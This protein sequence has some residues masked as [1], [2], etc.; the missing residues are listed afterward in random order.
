MDFRNIPDP[1]VDW[2]NIRY[3]ITSDAIR[4]EVGYRYCNKCKKLYAINHWNF[5]RNKNTPDGYSY[6]CK[7]CNKHYLQH[8]KHKDT[9]VDDIF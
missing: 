2:D 3:N 6:I 5:N 8:N 7:S 9:T 1:T 4:P